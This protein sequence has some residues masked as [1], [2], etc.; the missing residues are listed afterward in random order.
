MKSKNKKW[1]GF[2]WYAL[3]GLVVIT[4]ATN[5]V[6]SQPAT[7]AEW[8]YSKLLEE[9][10]K[11][12]A[13]VSRIRISSDRTSAEVTVAGGSEDNKKVRVKL[14]NDPNFIRT[15]TENNIEIDVAPRQTD[16]GLVQ[17]LRGLVW[18]LFGF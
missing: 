17:T 5:S 7:Q 11:K 13:G 1:R 12:P 15:M 2:G 8:S 18:L 3:L 16:S 9:V 4:L 6:A 14:P 10:R